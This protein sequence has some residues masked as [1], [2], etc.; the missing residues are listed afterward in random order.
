MKKRNVNK[1]LEL[2]KGTVIA[3]GGVYVHTVQKV[4]VTASK[5]TLKFAKEY[6]TQS[7]GA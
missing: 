7:Y 1:V 6:L 5:T 3:L 4:K 2:P